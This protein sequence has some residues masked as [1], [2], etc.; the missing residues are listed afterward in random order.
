MYYDLLH[1][2]SSY[3]ILLAVP[4]I[5]TSIGT[6]Q[7]NNVPPTKLVDRDYFYSITGTHHRN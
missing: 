6:V 7:E 2:C 4:Y 5:L 3:D 1:V